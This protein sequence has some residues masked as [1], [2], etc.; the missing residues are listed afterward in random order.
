MR[1]L[2]ALLSFLLLGSIGVTAQEYDTV[3]VCTYNLTRFGPTI[4]ERSDGST[5]NHIDDLKL[6][7]NEIQ[8][9]LLVVQ[10][11]SNREGFFLFRDSVA[12]ILDFP[13][14]CRFFP[15][16]S[17]KQQE[18]YSAIFIDG[19]A[20]ARSSAGVISDTPNV[21]VA[22]YIYPRRPEDFG[23]TDSLFIISGHLIEGEG[24]GHQ[25][26][27]L[28]TAEKLIRFY[29]YDYPPT[30]PHHDN[31]IFAGT[32]NVYTA[33][34]PAYR[35]LLHPDTGSLV[36]PIDRS[37][38]WFGNV[39][40]ADLH[41]QSTRVQTFDGESVGGMRGRFDQ[42]LLSPQLLDN[43]IPGSYTTFGND[44]NHFNDSINALPNL[45]VGPVM[46][47]ALHDASDHLPVYLDLVFPRVTTDV[48]EEGQSAERLDLVSRER[49]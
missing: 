31:A 23:W 43:V 17:N 14:T 8:P 33:D 6:I 15:E 46:A 1:R 32:L 36:D 35:A 16:R 34:E 13:L 40:F 18:S 30:N 28:Q 44:G 38:S 21:M 2:Y 4:S 37:G 47:Q 12:G 42:I 10:G 7:L 5:T 29:E 49:R 3:R 22:A 26:V 48:R 9:D 24:E 19:R 39:E 25:S 27:R 11:I 45:A 41:T 20:V